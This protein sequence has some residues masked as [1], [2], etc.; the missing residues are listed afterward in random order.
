M[1]VV[2]N[3]RALRTNGEGSGTGC[4]VLAESLGI[5][6]KLENGVK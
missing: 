3:Q 5:K 1:R 2:N 6:V 4:S